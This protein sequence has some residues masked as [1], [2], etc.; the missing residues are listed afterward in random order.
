M[1]PFDRDRVLT[2][3][4]LDNQ[5]HVMK[6]YGGADTSFTNQLQPGD[7]FTITASDRTDLVGAVYEVVGVGPMHSRGFL[8]HL[9]VVVIKRK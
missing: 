7:I 5:A 9:A 8:H 6:V 3:Y 2:R 1:T 4:K